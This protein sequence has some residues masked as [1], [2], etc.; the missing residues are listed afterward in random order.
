MS[1][2][3]RTATVTSRTPLDWAHVPDLG[4]GR[5]PKLHGMQGVRANPRSSSQP[6]EV[7]AATSLG[8]LKDFACRCHYHA[9]V[10]KAPV[11]VFRRGGH[12]GTRGFGS[13]SSAN[14]RGSGA[15]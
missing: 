1:G 6:A 7:S 14:R 4:F 9:S 10:C 8:Y 5:S 11:V 3:Q 12:G 2:I 15:T 13:K